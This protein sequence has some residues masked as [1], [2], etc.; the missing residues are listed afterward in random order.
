M[1]TRGQVGNPAIQR[2]ARGAQRLASVTLVAAGFL[3]LAACS[4]AP[5]CDKPEP[6]QKAREGDP[7]SVPEDLEHPT[8]S[9]KFDIPDAGLGRP[10]RGPCGDAPPLAPPPKVAAA[11]EK[12][13]TPVDDGPL[14]T[15]DTD[16]PSTVAGT[17]TTP[18]GPV[19]VSGG[20]ERDIRESVIAWATA[21]RTGDGDT[22]V[23]FYSKEYEPPVAGESREEWA[24]RRRTSLNATGPTD[25]RF[26]RLT[27]TETYAGVSAR[28]IQ[29]F[30]DRG[31]IDAVIKTL[32]FIVED[33]RWLISR[34]RVVEVL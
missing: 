24:E 17:P 29:E 21:L 10:V 9:G 27:V 2:V 6:F 14:P 15:L 19:A 1:R 30:H 3:A 33:G 12:D 28:F 11:P 34:E 20:L 26:D 23:T 22:L 16:N 31:R 18:G 32:D 13:S 7:L 5:K 25:I 8:S 4:S